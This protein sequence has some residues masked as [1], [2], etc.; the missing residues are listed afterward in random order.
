MTG[1]DHNG[2]GEEQER[3]YKVTDRRRFTPD[4]DLRDD[5][6]PQAPAE[7]EAE[8]VP[9]TDVPVPE[10]ELE[11]SAEAEPEVPS[12]QAEPPPPE[13]TFVGFVTL[14]SQLAMLYMGALRDP[15]GKELPKDLPTSRIFIDGLSIIAQKCEGN[16]SAGEQE[17][18][19]RIVYE[20]RM[21][22]VECS[23]S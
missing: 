14:I 1:D 10:A 23:K 2:D 16:L 12:E 11:A 7:P 4:G 21:A 3:G 18:M 8:T 22:F 17:M 13:T 19:Q 20:L 6:E 15:D 9:A 5:E